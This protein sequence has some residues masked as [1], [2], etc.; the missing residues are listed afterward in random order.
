MDWVFGFFYGV[1]I[2]AQKGSG[3]GFVLTLVS[4][5][6]FSVDL[7]SFIDPAAPGGIGTRRLGLSL[8]RI[9]GCSPAMCWL[10]SGSQVMMLGV[11]AR[12]TRS[13]HAGYD[14][15]GIV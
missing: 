11:A 4:G 6:D 14:E 12:T 5:C 10:P 13:H 7:G 2:L 15:S 3:W 1:G 8:S 9:S